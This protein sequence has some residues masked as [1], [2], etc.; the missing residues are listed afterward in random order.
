M[1]SLATKPRALQLLRPPLGDKGDQKLLKNGI[2]KGLICQ[3]LWNVGQGISPSPQ[4]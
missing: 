1:A 3:W 2:Q 4:L